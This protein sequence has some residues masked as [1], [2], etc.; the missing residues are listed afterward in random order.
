MGIRTFAGQATEDIFNG[1]SSKATRKFP[2]D[3]IRTARRKLDLINAAALIGD[4]SAPPGNHLEKMKGDW[5][6]FY[7][8]RVN[9]QFRIVFRFDSGNADDV[10]LIDYH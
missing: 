9:D 1:V 8:I 7:S 4:L 10:Q 6:G 3:M 2:A 5:P